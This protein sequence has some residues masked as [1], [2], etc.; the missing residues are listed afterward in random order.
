[1]EGLDYKGCIDTVVRVLSPSTNTHAYKNLNWI[2]KCKK[3]GRLEFLDVC[4]FIRR[5]KKRTL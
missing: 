5:L 4:L 3:N 1:M 2:L